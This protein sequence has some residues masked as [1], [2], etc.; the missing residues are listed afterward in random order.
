[1]QKVR[2]GI[3]ALKLTDKTQFDQ[4]L[5]EAKTEVKT[6]LDAQDNMSGC[7]IY[8]LLGLEKDDIVVNL[9]HFCIAI[10]KNYKVV[11]ERIIFKNTF[12]FFFS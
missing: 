8:E 4:A 12:F 2:E 10:K 7:H 3:D 11:F 1:M 9:Q 6:F 5:E